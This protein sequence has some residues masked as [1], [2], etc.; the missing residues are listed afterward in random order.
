MELLGLRPQSAKWAGRK[1]GE[2]HARKAWRTNSCASVSAS[3]SI[4]TSNSAANVAR[5]NFV[6][7]SDSVRC[8]PDGARR[9]VQREEGPS[10]LRT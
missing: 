1:P 5:N 9:L 2:F 8:P 4:G 6:Q 7:G 10:P 3:S